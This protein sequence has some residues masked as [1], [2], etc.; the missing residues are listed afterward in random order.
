M[1]QLI[2]AAVAEKVGFLRAA[3]HKGLNG[4]RRFLSF[5]G[6]RARTLAVRLNEWLTKLRLI[7]LGPEELTA[8]VFWAA[9]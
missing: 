7:V 5:A 2:A 9:L 8:I 6:A 3:D 4:A 1:S